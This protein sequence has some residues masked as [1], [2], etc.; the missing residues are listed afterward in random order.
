MAKMSLKVK[1]NDP[2]FQYQL[3]VSCDAC[4]VQIWWF[5]LQVVMSY[6]ACQQEVKVYGQMDGRTDGW[7]D[8]QTQATT[9]PFGLLSW[10][11]IVIA[12]VCPLVHPSIHLSICP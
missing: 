12:C 6:H 11:G 3:R 5:Q 9:I 1:V 10:K 8:G 7:T 2:Y 4:L